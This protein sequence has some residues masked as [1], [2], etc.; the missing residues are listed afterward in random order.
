MRPE[1]IF[2]IRKVNEDFFY[3]PGNDIVVRT[4][5]IV[6]SGAIFAADPSSWVNQW[7]ETMQAG[8]TKRIP[9]HL[10]KLLE[11]LQESSLYADFD[12][13]IASKKFDPLI[14]EAL[15]MGVGACL[16]HAFSSTLKKTTVRMVSG[17]V[18]APIPTI[19]IDAGMAF[20]YQ[21][22]KDLGVS[23]E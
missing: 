3:H 21:R 15:M 23:F 2:G 16:L 19:D 1:N 8:G 4:P 12:Q 6:V 22:T 5:S 13:V 14:F 11:V 20:F 9:G 10:K 7:L 17:K 18:I